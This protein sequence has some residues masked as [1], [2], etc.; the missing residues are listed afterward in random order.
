MF[1]EWSFFLLAHL[2]EPSESIEKLRI[3]CVIRNQNVKR[4]FFLYFLFSFVLSSSLVLSS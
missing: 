4:L 3:L 2:D 1:C